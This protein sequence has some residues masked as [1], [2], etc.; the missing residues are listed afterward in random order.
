MC[1]VDPDPTTAAASPCVDPTR[2]AGVPATPVSPTVGRARSKNR[3]VHIDGFR[4]AQSGRGGENWC[5]APG[6]PPP[7]GQGNRPGSRDSGET[8]EEARAVRCLPKGD[9][10]PQGR[11]PRRPTGNQP[12]AE[13]E[14][15]AESVMRP[16]TCAEV[17]IPSFACL[18]TPVCILSHSGHVRVDW[19]GNRRLFGGKAAAG[20]KAGHRAVAMVAT[21]VLAAEAQAQV[22]D[23]LDSGTALADISTRAEIAETTSGSTTE[24]S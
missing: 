11:R 8:D 3:S 13:S 4:A 10:P 21:S 2:S 23:L 22:A 14:G 7:G 12:S 9:S 15:G 16:T 6:R 19:K 1:Q 24:A 18:L 17:A 5:A 20:D